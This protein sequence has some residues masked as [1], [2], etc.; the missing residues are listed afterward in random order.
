MNYEVRLRNSAQKQLDGIRGKEYGKI[1]EAISSLD[2]NPRP[3]K[4]KKLAE[5]GLWCV[6]VGKYRVIYSIDDKAKVI[7]VV[8]VAKR[9]KDT[10]KGL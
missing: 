9:S 6:R 8:R 1:A 2:E 5:S 3:S 7:I 10:Y 4:G